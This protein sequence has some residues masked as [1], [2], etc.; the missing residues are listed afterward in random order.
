MLKSLNTD[1][2]ATVF[3]L[4]QNDNICAARAGT[5]VECID[6]VKAGEK[7]DIAYRK[8]RNKVLVQHR[9]G[10]VGVYAVTAPFKLLVKPG[11]KVIPG[12]P[13]AVLNGASEKY[14]LY[15]SVCYLEESKLVTATS[16][17]SRAYYSYMPTVFYGSEKERSSLLQAG[18][19]YIVQHPKAMI[20]AETK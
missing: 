6:T 17:D 10:T 5:V 19:E 13:L 14:K 8:D 7:S 16:F 15:F 12:Q 3:I 18:K 11:D 1:Y 4:K 20:T 9:D 2:R